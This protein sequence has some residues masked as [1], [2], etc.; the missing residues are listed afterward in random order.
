MVDKFENDFRKKFAKNYSVV[1]TGSG[2]DSSSFSLY[3]SW[4]QKR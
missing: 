4:P 1:A 3:S 2:T